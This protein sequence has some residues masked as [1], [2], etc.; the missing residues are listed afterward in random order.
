MSHDYLN[1]PFYSIPV[2]HSIEVDLRHEK[3]ADDRLLALQPVPVLLVF[4]AEVE[5]HL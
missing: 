2:V 1:Y 3:L 4:L 5:Y